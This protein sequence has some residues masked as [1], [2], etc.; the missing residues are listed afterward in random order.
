[1]FNH[2]HLIHPNRLIETVQSEINGP[3]EIRTEFGRP[4]VIVNHIP[5]SGGIV[6]DILKKGLN[7]FQNPKNFLLL[8]VGGGAILHKISQ[9]WPDCRITAVEIDPVMVQI[10]N[11]YFQINQ[12]P[13]LKIINQDA[14]DFI[15]LKTK[16]LKLKTKYDAIL[17][18]CYIG[19]QIPPQ[20]ESYDFLQTL[21]TILSPNGIIVF[22]RLNNKSNALKTQKFIQTLQ[23]LFPQISQ[24]SIYCNIIVTATL[25]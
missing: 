1:M 11:Q 3:I 14:Y 6:Q 10:A 15:K 12:I 24:K 8:G 23:P 4:R 16:N 13:H 25:K 2:L 18:D 20:L 22:N 7:E 17:V 5:Q 21:K 19:D 9:R